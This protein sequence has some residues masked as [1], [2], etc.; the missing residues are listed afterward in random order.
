MWADSLQLAEQQHLIRLFVWSEASLLIGG[1]MLALL[2]WKRIPSPL[3]RHF[4]IQTAAWG[5]VSLL[6]AFLAWR[7]LALRD[8]EGAVELDRLVWL[9]IGLDLG[10]V[11]VGVTLAVT[12]WL[13]GRRMGPVGAGLAIVIQGAALAALDWAF[14]QQILR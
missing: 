3:L 14:A 9:N 11:A 12:G 5:A 1:V 6:L 8:H 2:L 13:A 10:Y 4:A 7:G